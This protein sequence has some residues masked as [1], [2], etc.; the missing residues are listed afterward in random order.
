VPPRNNAPY[1]ERHITILNDQIQTTRL[2]ESER[3]LLARVARGGGLE[4]VLNDIVLA[5]EKASGGE[6]LASILIVSEDGSRLTQGAAPSL[7]A[8]YNAAINGIAIGPKAGSCGTAAFRGEPVFVSD[9]ANDPLWLRR[10]VWP[11]A[12]RCRSAA[13]MAASLAPLP[14]IT[15]SRKAPASA[16][17]KPSR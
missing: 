4:E 8:D 7:A 15:T 1:T 10:M 17:S 16:I 2:L 11:P 9:I 5:V 6:M 12:G 14:T 3:E 13:P